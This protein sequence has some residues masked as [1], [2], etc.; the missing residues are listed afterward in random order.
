MLDHGSKEAQ[1]S[2][3]LLTNSPREGGEDNAALI[4]SASSKNKSKSC[5]Y[6]MTCGYC[7]DDSEQK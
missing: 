3:Q 7:F 2:E 5:L 1:V 4:L 6:Y